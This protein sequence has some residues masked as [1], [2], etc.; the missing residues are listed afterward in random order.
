MNRISRRNFLKRTTA[1]SAAAVAGVQYGYSPRARAA[2]ANDAIRLAVVGL[3]ST[4]KI[5]GKGKQD[6]RAFRK[7]P[8][9]RV[10][11][12]C[13][14][15]SAILG[16]Q[17]DE[18]RKRNEAVEAY[19]DVRK[20]LESKAVDAIS[21]TT[22]NHWHALATV[23]ACQAG[24]DVFVQKPASHN[25]FEGR[26]MVEAA[27][28]YNRVV[29]CTSGSRE[30]NG[31]REAMDFVHQGKLG[32]LLV[33]RGLN[34]RPRTSIGK[35]SGAQ[36]IPEA[37]N[38]DLWCGPAP[39]A[40]LRRQNLHYDWHWDWSTGNGD[41]GNMGIHNLDGCRMAVG[42][43][44]P[45]HVISIG[46]RF[47]YED[48]G[49]T[50]NSQLIFFDY[51]RAPILFEVRGLPKDKSFLKDSWAGKESWGPKAMDEYMGVSVGK[52]IHCEEGHV[53][54]NKAFDRNGA[55]IREFQPTTPNLYQNFVQTMRTRRFEDLVADIEEGHLSASLVHLANISHRVGK[56]APEGEIRERV[57]GNRELTA[58]YGRFK[59]HLLA[60][61]IDLE[62]TPATLGAMLTIDPQTERFVGEFSEAANR[63]VSR[64]YRRPFVVPEK[65]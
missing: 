7:I 55:L 52:V 41:L 5:G 17:V 61:G 9:V 33:A 57:Q 28:K 50:P 35:V 62:K 18:A 14:V 19:T 29:L 1:A 27:R 23:W 31:F 56:T 12:F 20:L 59:A 4:V 2:G 54:G 53:I 34:Y 58:A 48:D 8:G 42:D 44:W 25:I 51:E 13:D 39:T 26:K 32:K 16:Q 11:A 65:V 47:G 6:A 30:A 49:E 45:R 37:V 22:P 10:V 64:E 63:L 46:G 36:P 21:V 3:G 24:K 38:Y 60:N 15:D 40:L 43:K